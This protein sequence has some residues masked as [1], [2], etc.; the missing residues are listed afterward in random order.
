MFLFPLLHLPNQTQLVILLPIVLH[1]SQQQEYAGRGTW[2]AQLVKHLSSPAGQDP[3]VP[4]SSPTLCFLL[5]RESASSPAL[6]NLCL[7]SLALSQINK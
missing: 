3:R 1:S 4:G 6:P 7:L 5:S 2:V